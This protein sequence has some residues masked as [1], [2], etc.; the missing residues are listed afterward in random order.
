MAALSLGGGS[1][2]TGTSLRRLAMAWA[3]GL[4]VSGC[5]AGGEPE[6]PTPLAF[7]L[8][9]P[10]MNATA[11]DTFDVLFDTSKGEIV[12]EVVR[13]WAPLGADRF[14]SLVRAGY[15]D[16]VR[17]FRNIEGFMVQFGM[18]GDPVV[19]QTWRM[20]RINDDP[21]RESNTRGTITFATAGPNSRTTQV[22]INHGNNAPLDAQ[23][24]APFGRVTRGMDV[25]ERLYAGYGE[26]PPRGRGPDQGLIQAEGNAYLNSRF[27]LLD[28]IE[29]ATIVEE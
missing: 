27:P 17:F 11:P 29:R 24:F 20:A 19:T 8:L 4:G 18:H 12:V 16:G 7:H 5:A 23:G 25:L 22:F 13:E 15:Y 6:T 10:E 26:G 2:V 14:Y 1:A 21:V 3:L 28:Y 9:D